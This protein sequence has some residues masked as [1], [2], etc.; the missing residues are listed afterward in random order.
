MPSAHRAKLRECAV[1]RYESGEGSYGE[2]AERFGVGARTLER[3]VQRYRESGEL[4][5]RPR[6]GGWQSPI[7]RR[8]LDK[9]VAAEP[10]ASAAELTK[11][12]NGLG[13]TAVS[14]SSLLRGLRRAGYVFKKNA[15]DWRSKIVRT[16]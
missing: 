11:A 3:W 9:V 10:D 12:Y 13:P 1:V 7:V 8:V 5:A 15:G 4:C 14:R 16:S 6:G 2:V